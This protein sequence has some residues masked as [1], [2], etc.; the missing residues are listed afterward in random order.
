MPAKINIVG[1]TFGILE[2]IKDAPGTVTA[3]G[4]KVRQVE[5]R[6]KKCGRIRIVRNINLLSGKIDSCECSRG[7]NIATHGQARRSGKSKTYLYW[8]Q[9]KRSPFFFES[10]WMSYEPFVESVGEM[11][12][13]FKTLAM[14]DPQIG[15]I[16]GNVKWSTEAKKP[17]GR[18]RKHAA[19]TKGDVFGSWTV[20]GE[21]IDGPTHI[22]APCVCKC[23]K[24]RAII[25]YHLLSGA[26]TSCG[27][28]KPVKHGHSRRGKLSATYRTWQ[29][30]V[31]RCHLTTHSKYEQY[32]G[33][34]ITV[35]DR[36][37]EFEDFLADMGIAPIGCTIDR[38]NNALGYFKDNCRWAT[39]FQQAE[40]KVGI[41]KHTIRGVTG[42]L[43]ALCRHFEINYHR[44]RKRITD[45]GWD[46][47]RAMFTPSNNRRT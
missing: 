24:V 38:I 47:E 18:M 13:G 31:V 4:K 15:Y 22:M 14:I 1:K 33:K 17:I 39:A 34:G 40:N 5:C 41:V 36:W 21:L 6:C 44:T 10:T 12:D 37:R 11:P 7:D 43:S 42:C 35:C 29:A 32:G 3:G 27:C 23:G 20:S 19:I 30:M 8:K 26:S 2:V 9:L 46:V 16:A 28:D 45:F 25:I